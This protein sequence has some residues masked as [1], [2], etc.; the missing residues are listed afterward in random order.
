M[1]GTLCA[2][3]D[4]LALPA[5]LE[6]RDLVTQQRPDHIQK[7]DQLDHHCP[8]W[9]RS[10]F[11]RR[12]VLLGLTALGIPTLAGC[13]GEARS[14]SLL[15]ATPSSALAASPASL[16][17][18]VL[19]SPG[20]SPAAT[21][22]S[23]SPA[24][25]HATPEPSPLG[26]LEVIRD[27]HPSYAGEPVRGG[28]LRL[29]VPAIDREDFNPVAFR[30]DFQVLASHLDPLVWIDEVT[31][32]PRPG[33]AERWEWGDGG[34]TITY[35]LRSDVIWHDDS[36]L[37]AKD[38]VFSLFVS[39]DDV[40]SGIANLFVLMDNAEAIG[41]QKVKVTLTEPDG[42][43]LLNASTQFIFQ[44]AQYSKYWQSRPEGE[45]TLAGYDWRENAP[46]GTGPWKVGKRERGRVAFSRNAGY[47]AGAPYADTLTISAEPKPEKQ[48]EGWLRNKVDVVWPVPVEVLADLGESKGR[49]YVVDSPSVMFAAF[50]F[51]NPARGNPN[52]FA[53]VRIRRAI[54]LAVDRER[55]AR[56]IFSGFFRP[57]AAGTVAQPW[58]YDPESRNPPRDAA[59][60][61]D[62]L[63]EA[64]CDDRDDDGTLED[65]TGQP[66]EI[67]LIL[68]ND[69]RPE[70]ER[71][72]RSVRSDLAKVGIR[73]QVQ[74]LA[75]DR[76]DERWRTT[77]DFDLIAY[78]YRLYPGFTDFDLYGSGWDIRLNPLGF[79]PGGYRNR[80]VDAA[81]G[82]ILSEVDVDR[83]R[84]ALYQLQQ[85]ANED[86]FGLWLGFPQDLVL[87]QPHVLGFQPH[88]AWP[89]WGTRHLWF[90]SGLGS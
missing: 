53:D 69:A 27:P 81:I 66:L 47:W 22:V 60:A 77:H 46:I 90:S 79:N 33:L 51:N 28:D 30:Q 35:T 21:P 55:Y 3:S 73:L 78:A 80:D 12:R 31:M 75:P 63:K 10:R 52:L 86:L 36:P 84:Q 62:L 88:V 37:T 50:N 41:D 39:R 72:L 18:Q 2:A 42:G 38:V 4:R 85:A 9:L 44:R 70:L 71:V 82:T 24:T 26:K 20:A 13:R 87:V 32:E 16:T 29:L 64:G 15:G 48:V 5:E 1:D 56:D 76:F 54:S 34:Q 14:S 65:E 83:Q 67:V 25:S 57:D 40:N 58:A 23:D 19:A 61:R 6:R 45:R 43:W 17:S 74:P 7:L 49:L 8:S 11:D 59:A 89:T 68:R